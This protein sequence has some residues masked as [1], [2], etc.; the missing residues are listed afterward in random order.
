MRARLAWAMASVSLLGVALVG[1]G[2]PVPVTHTDN[3][4]RIFLHGT[5]SAGRVVENS[6]G[7][8]GMGCAMCHGHEG[9]G[10]MMHGIPAP[11][12]TYA[13][14]TDPKGHE[15]GFRDRRHPPFTRGRN[16]HA[17]GAGIDPAGN[18]LHDRMPRGTGLRP[19]GLE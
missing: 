2:A 11:D 5:T 18:P 12:I 4:R 10:G 17:I 15:H 13:V 6:H 1:A 3:G 8:E 7:M 16:K 14:L 19:A 9:R